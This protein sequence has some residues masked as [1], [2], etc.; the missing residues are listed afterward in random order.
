VAQCARACAGLGL[1]P[2]FGV[3]HS[4]R[5][6]MVALAWDFYELLRVRTETAVFAF[7]GSRK[8]DASEFKIE[9]K[10]K[11]HV[12]FGSKLGR[13]L[14]VHVVRAIPFRVVVKTCREVAGWL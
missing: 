13:E 9:R 2:A 6:G 12:K 4:A 14:A 10:P 1:D 5:P 7:I 8:F 3:L 11:P